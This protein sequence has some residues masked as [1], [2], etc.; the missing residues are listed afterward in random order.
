MTDRGGELIVGILGQ[1]A[2]GK[3]AAA[4][5]LL[6]TLGG[7]ERAE[8]IGDRELF[9]SQAVKHLRDL[10]QSRVR[11]RV[12][13]DG[14]QRLEGDLATVWLRPGEDLESAALEALQF[15]VHDDVMAPWLDESRLA[16]GCLIRARPR[17]G[18]PIIVEAGFGRNPADHTLADLFARLAEA[19]VEPT[20]VRWIIVEASYETRLERNLK[21]RIGTPPDVFEKYAAAGGDLTPAEQRRLEEQ[22]VVIRRVRNDHDDIERFRA[23]IVA[24][25]GEM[26]GDLLPAAGVGDRQDEA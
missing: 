2:S 3:S 12:E 15:D 24:A 25:F 1:W 9:A 4:R 17:R 21:R 19:G 26:F 13:D 20:R 7:R 23:D 18:K 22:G 5:T 11:L 6:Q 16:L 10:G 14:R 8:F